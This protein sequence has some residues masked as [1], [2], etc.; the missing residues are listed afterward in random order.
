MSAVHKLVEHPAPVSSDTAGNKAVGLRAQTE[1]LV[2]KDFSALE[3]YWGEDY[4]QHQPGLRNGLA[5]LKAFKTAN[6]PGATTEILLC[7][8]D[9]DLVFFHQRVTGFMPVPL[10][11]FDV[12]RIEDGRIV[13]HWDAFQPVEG[14]NRSG[15]SFFDGQL[16]ITDTGQTDATRAL[17]LKCVN[18]VFILEQHDRIADYVDADLI[19]HT[20]DMSDGIA[21]LEQRFRESQWFTG[22]LTYHAVRRIVAEGDF[23]A[24]CSEGAVD[25]DPHAFYDLFRVAAGR[26]VEHWS[27]RQQARPSQFHR[28]PRV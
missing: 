15:R 19:Q 9:R 10:G 23:A 6:V 2:D 7:L 16:E 18:N 12:Y 27:L 1:L 22:A 26:I 4:I 25:G 17:A 21:G 5:D 13:E 11:F 8:G 24:V 3:R 28:N 14:A 20:P